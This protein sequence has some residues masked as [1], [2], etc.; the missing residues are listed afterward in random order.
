M[1]LAQI[2][3]YL[4]ELHQIIVFIEGLF[5]NA[6]QGAAKLDAA[7]TMAT[8]L[9]P[10]VTG[11]IDTLKTVISAAVTTMNAAGTLKPGISD[12]TVG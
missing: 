4:P 12:T 10:E 6:K 2:L 11:K 9:I 5:P 7:V 1:S 3:S 8:Q